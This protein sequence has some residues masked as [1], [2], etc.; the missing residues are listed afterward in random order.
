M[1]SSFS[2]LRAS[3]TFF[4]RALRYALARETT[5][6]VCIFFRTFPTAGRKVMEG[7]GGCQQ[8]G[9][10]GFSAL[11]QLGG[12]DRIAIWSAKTMAR[13]TRSLKEYQA[14]RNF[15]KSPEPSG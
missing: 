8:W 10:I 7:Y 9:C 15:Q 2:S 6:L 3:R 4:C 14:K 5:G 13:A 11:R 12:S 1:P